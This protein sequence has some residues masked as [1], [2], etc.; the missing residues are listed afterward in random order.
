MRFEALMAVKLSMLVFDP[1]DGGSMFLRNVGTHIQVHTV[2][3]LS[4]PT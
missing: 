2:S 4:T 1:E 3:Q